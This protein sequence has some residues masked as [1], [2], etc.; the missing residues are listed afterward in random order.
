MEITK[1]G[2]GTTRSIGNYEN[3]KVYLEAE[4][5]EGENVDEVFSKLQQQADSYAHQHREIQNLAEV[6]R[7]LEYDARRYTGQLSEAKKQFEFLKEKWDKA[8]AFLEQ[9][10]VEVTA[11][12][13]VTP[14]LYNESEQALGEAT[15]GNTEKGGKDLGDIPF[16]SAEF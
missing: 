9:H 4:V 1:V 16:K 12:F 8:K 14:C 13:P 7:Y 3:C 11:Q 10:G 2:Y 15:T 5:N 6:A